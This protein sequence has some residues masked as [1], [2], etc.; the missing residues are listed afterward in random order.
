MLTND[1]D[2]RTA[3]ELL[4]ELFPSGC[5][6]LARFAVE[7]SLARHRGRVLEC[8]A[9]YVRKCSKGTTITSSTSSP[10]VRLDSVRVEVRRI[11][12]ELADRIAVGNEQADR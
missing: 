9:D 1:L 2:K 8:V 7:L 12:E 11:L 4:R 10:F 3:D 5:S 6:P